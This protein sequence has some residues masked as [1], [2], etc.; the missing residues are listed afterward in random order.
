M[1]VS[2]IG[3][4]QLIELLTETL[5]Q[6]AVLLPGEADA[7]GNRL[8]LAIGDDAAAWD[9]PAGT[10]VFT[11]DTM[12][13]GGHFVLDQ[14]GWHGLGWKAMVVNLSDIAAMGCLP[15]YSIVTLGLR[16]ELPVDGLVQM[17]RGIAEACHGFGGQVVGGDIVRSPVFFVTV[18]MEGATMAQ[19]ETGQ[20]ALLTRGAAKIGDLVAVTGTLGDSAG[21]FRIASAGTPFDNSTS[22]L[23]GAHFRPTPRLAVGQTLVNAG[24]KAAMDISDGLMGDL[25]KFCQASGVGAVVH[26][27][28]V[29]V[30][31]ELIQKFPDDWLS[32]ALTGGEDY[33]LLFAATEKV[34]EE[35][36]Q[37][38]DVPVTI[39]GKIVD[40]AEG[41]LVID[42]AGSPIDVGHAGWDHF[43]NV[44]RQT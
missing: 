39:I 34:V 6:E 24:G 12:V 25:Q 28:S 4:F 7:D 21:G 33:E 32:L 10:R 37:T 20:G 41:V 29:P 22:R 1:L 11:T 35:A 2:D 44:K 43:K 17:Y 14:I 31:D 30:S 36:R 18:A 5:D 26:A 13:E 38:T 27:D 3:E 42:E 23:R 19:D 15:T 40:S 16:D 8:R 9:S